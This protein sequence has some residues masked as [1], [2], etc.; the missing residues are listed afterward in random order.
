MRIERKPPVLV[1]GRARGVG[2]AVFPSAKIKGEAPLIFRSGFTNGL[3]V[4]VEE[5]MRRQSTSF[6]HTANLPTRHRYFRE[7]AKPAVYGL[8]QNHTGILYS[9]QCDRACRK[10]TRWF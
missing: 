9:M 10:P 3:P 6:H 5:F 4:T 7:L 2:T 8:K 1:R